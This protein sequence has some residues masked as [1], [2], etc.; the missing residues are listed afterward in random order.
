MHVYI[1]RLEVTA[2]LNWLQA[3]LVLGAT[4]LLGLRLHWLMSVIFMC[5]TVSP[6][7]RATTLSDRRGASDAGEAH[8][9]AV[10]CVYHLPFYC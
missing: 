6:V 1:G 9:A 3:G 2:L 10:S 8:A 7:C 5:Q 4:P